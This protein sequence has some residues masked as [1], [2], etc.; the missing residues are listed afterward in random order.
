M[1][2][3]SCTSPWQQCRAMSNI[4]AR[5]QS[6]WDHPVQSDHVPS[7]AVTSNID[8]GMHLVLN[9]KVKTKR[10]LQKGQAT[11]SSIP[12]SGK[13][14]IWSQGLRPAIFNRQSWI[15]QM[16]PMHP[17]I[18]EGYCNAGSLL[19][20]FLVASYIRLIVSLVA[21]ALHAL[22]VELQQS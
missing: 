6:Q 3:V 20:T 10:F 9:T 18:K 16:C 7:R 11:A 13:R 8:L 14:S 4:F 21:C 12:E 15:C 22:H 17:S 5:S 2:K 19:T 1:S